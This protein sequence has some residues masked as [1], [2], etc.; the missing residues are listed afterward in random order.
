MN[1]VLIVS[2]KDNPRRRD[3]SILIARTT[4]GNSWGWANTKFR[5]DDQTWQAK[6]QKLANDNTASAA[7]ITKNNKADI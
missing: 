5:N 6:Q 7:I 2:C 3:N 1:S 4:P